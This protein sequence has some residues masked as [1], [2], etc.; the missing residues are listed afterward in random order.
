MLP[1]LI[2][3]LC[4]LAATVIIHAAVLTVLL[5]RLA[6]APALKAMGFWRVA[7]LLV[8]VSWVLLI[9]HLVEIGLWA[10][11][12]WWLKCLPDLEASLYFSGVTYATL[13]YG[14]VLL[15]QEWRLLGPLEALTGT[16]LCGLSV[17][18][19]F[20][21]LSRVVAART[22]LGRSS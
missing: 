20:V 5:R 12:F 1:E 7:S 19:F 4:L 11:L 17:S 10:L 8:S 21:L 9:L 15:A 18:F 14:D 2:A 22:T 6:E 13:G 3:A 16:L